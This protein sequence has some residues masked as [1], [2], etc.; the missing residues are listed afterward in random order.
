MNG[1]H[2]G[3]WRHVQMVITFQLVIRRFHELH[4]PGAK[5]GYYDDKCY[6]SGPSAGAA[7]LFGLSVTVQR[8]LIEKNESQNMVE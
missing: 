8:G 2:F 3:K 6:Y 1:G 7:G 4:N 5:D